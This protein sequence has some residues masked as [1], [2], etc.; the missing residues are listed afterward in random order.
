MMNLTNSSVRSHLILSGALAATAAL[1]PGAL[2]NDITPLLVW[3]ASIDGAA[4]PVDP[5]YTEAFSGIALGGRH[6][7]VIVYPGNSIRGWGRSTEGQITVPDLVGATTYTMVAAGTDHTA[8]LKSDGRIVCVGANDDG[9][10]EVPAF[11]LP[12]DMVRCGSNFTLARN[13]NGDIEAWGANGTGAGSAPVLSGRADDFAGG[14][15]HAVALL[16]DGTIVFW[17]DNSQGE[18]TQP[19]LSGSTV[20]TAVAAGNNFTAFL[21]SDGTVEVVGDNSLG[22]QNVPALGAGQTYTSVRANAFTVGAR[23]SDDTT[24]IWGNTSNDLDD[25]PADP[26]GYRFEDFAIG[27]GFAGAL[28]ALDCDDDGLSDLV[29]ISGD[30]TLD[31]NGDRRL[32]SCEP[33]EVF[34]ASGTVSPFGAGSTVTVGD[35]DLPD[36]FGEV[37]VEVE[38]KA[39]MGSPGEYLTLALNGQVIDYLFL[40]N[41]Q[42]CAASPQKETIRI[43]A[44]MFNA[45]LIEGDAE[46]TLT[47]SP[48]VSSTEC[49]TSSATVRFEYRYDGADCNDN[50]IPDSCEIVSGNV[51]DINN[52]GIP[53]TCE[54]KPSGD[55][56]GDRSGDI[57]WYN[58]TTRGL[59]VWF[60][61]GLN[62]TSGGIFTEFVPSGFSFSGMGDLDGDG[63]HDFVLRNTATGAVRV[64]LNAGTE[65]IESA[66]LSSTAA[67]VLDLLAVVD[68]DRDGCADLVWR[69]SGTG[70]V[71]GWLMKG[72]V[73]RIGAEIGTASNATFLGAGDLDAD[74]DADL[75]WKLADDTVSGWLMNGLAIQSQGA[76][77]GASAVAD[78]FVCEGVGDLDGNG[79]AD[80]VW[81]SS[82]TGDVNAWF[83]DGLTKSSGGL[84][85]DTIG[86]GF[87]ISAII[88][89]DGDGKRDIVW[90][91]PSNG[92]IYAWLMNGLTKRSGAFVR[93]SSTAW[94]VVNP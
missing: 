44:S 78:A 5:S 63:R 92:D 46:F 36:A 70:K 94:R 32:D 87:R 75:L 31:C 79:T 54:L 61:E 57:V 69:S 11:F 58:S 88:D 35:I 27:D 47:P 41:G 21:K 89:L 2:A 76:I 64:M 91:R 28:Y 82:E 53:D 24:V 13:L 23:R 81:R 34:V 72:Q 74:G 4:T 14:L 38:V 16:G 80:I 68:L 73:R 18:Q 85:T 3:G 52:N 7:L 49:A 48:L 50:G 40:A 84:I 37:V 43:A 67:A 8:L 15:D 86:L 45:M 93:A 12:Y 62:R 10:C 20:V 30:I 66:T 19:T 59:S 60:M 25:A 71:F 17:G 1:A 90:R 65:V 77:S 22:Q 9:Q 6:G 83:M 42:N 39:D 51:P 29:E 55:I 56:D 26:E 33:G